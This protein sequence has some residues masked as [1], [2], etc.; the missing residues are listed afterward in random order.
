MCIINTYNFFP[1]ITVYTF[2]AFAASQDYW[3]LLNMFN[4]FLFISTDSIGISLFKHS[5]LIVTMMD[6]T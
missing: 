6:H 1:Y 2:L 3:S 5:F 4:P